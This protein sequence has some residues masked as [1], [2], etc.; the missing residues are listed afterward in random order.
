MLLGVLGIGLQPAAATTHFTAGPAEFVAPGVQH[1]IWRAN[2][3]TPDVHVVQAAAAAHVSIRVVQAEGGLAGGRET[4]SGLCRRTPRC[5]AAVNGDFFTDAGPV[6]GVIV[7]NRMVRSPVSG[8][9][10]LSLAPLRAS[11]GGLGA[12][13]WAG[14][15]QVAGRVPT[16]VDGV[17]VPGP[18]DSV[19]LYTSDYGATTPACDCTELVLTGPGGAAANLQASE[20]FTPRDRASGTTALS[21]QQIVLAGH[22]RGAQQLQ[23]LWALQTPLVVEVRVAEPSAS[24]LG[25]HPIILQDGR[26]AAYDEQDPMLA[27][28]EPR[29]AVAWDDQG[30]VWLIAADG[31]QPGG[32]G[33]T[34]AET[35]SFVRQL[36]AQHAVLEDGGGSTTLVVAGRVA[37]RPSDGHQ[38]AVSNAVLLIADAQ[39]AAA[40]RAPLPR[41]TQFT[42]TSG[43]IT[44]VPKPLA[45]TVVRPAIAPSKAR[46]TVAAPRSRAARVVRPSRAQA[47]DEQ[48]PPSVVPARPQMV[49]LSAEEKVP[50]PR[51]PAGY[52]LAVVLVSAA[53][54]LAAVRSERRR[55]PA[56][57]SKLPPLL[58]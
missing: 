32:A 50:A 9:E 11:S 45:R 17:N 7:D 2:R 47:V 55:L 6:G 26:P 15:V 41:A 14:A 58:E 46:R 22:G 48:A 54:W 3:S 49:T 43:R 28:P 5:L 13:G 44:V 34:A 10:Q 35:V 52:A 19:V 4:T 56:Y 37:N 20:P 42:G 1:S 57:R 12:R 27:E 25:A 23:E 18:V 21:A 31:R 38:R 24:N 8:H 33:L 53:A 51:L 36:G 39:A 29:T 16:A 40:R 30:R